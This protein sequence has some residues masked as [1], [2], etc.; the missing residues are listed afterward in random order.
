LKPQ[1]AFKTELGHVRPILGR[2][3]SFTTTAFFNR[4]KN[5]IDLNQGRYDNIYKVDS[6]GAE[7]E[8]VFTASKRYQAS[9][10]YA[11]MDY[12][13]QSDYRLSETAPQTIELSHTLALP[14]KA[15]LSLSTLYMDSRLSQDDSG[16]YHILPHTGSTT[17][18]SAC[19]TV[20]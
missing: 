13:Q 19:H 8:L 15:R 6:Y 20:L 14:Q 1:S 10:S 18:V 11:W 9:L 16:N 17:Q 4:T 2:K 5:L 12:L 3:I 7:A